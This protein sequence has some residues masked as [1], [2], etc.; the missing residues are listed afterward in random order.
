MSG[1]EIVFV[2]ASSLHGLGVFFAIFGGFF[3]L[4]CVVFN[5][6]ASYADEVDKEKDAKWWK[7]YTASVTKWLLP[8]WLIA[9][10]F[11]NVPRVE[12]LWKIRIGLLKFGLASPTNVQGGIDHITKVGKELECRYL[13]LNCPVK[14]K[15]N[16]TKSE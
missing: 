16:E 7:K 10:I 11:A 1:L 14:E 15:A 6:V 2:I 3:L 5:A 8:L 12:D 13:Q 4:A 9:L